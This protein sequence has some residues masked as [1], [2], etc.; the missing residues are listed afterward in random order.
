MAYIVPQ[1]SNSV[2]DQWI[3]QWVWVGLQI[4]FAPYRMMGDS[5]LE[6][7]MQHFT[8]NGIRSNLCK[9]YQT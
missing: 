4:Y 9:P 2:L 6:Q 1:Q 8:L 7:F 5:E 3:D